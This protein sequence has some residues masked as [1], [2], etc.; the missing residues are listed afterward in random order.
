MKQNMEVQCPNTKIKVITFKY[1]LSNSYNQNI[2]QI[3]LFLL[4]AVKITCY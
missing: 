4:K 2:L 1:P 3:Y